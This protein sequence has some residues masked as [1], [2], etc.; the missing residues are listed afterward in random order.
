MENVEFAKIF[1]EIAEFLEIEG[2]NPFK[3]RAYQ[4]AALNIEGLSKNLE[5]IYKQGGLKAL[6]DIP[7]IGERI[8][9][10][11]EEII[12]KGR[13][14]LHQ[15]LLKKFPADFLEMIRI[16]GMGPKTVMMLYKKQGIDS[17]SMLEQ[18]AKFGKLRALPGMGEKKE[19]NILKGLELL[20]R[21]SGRYLLVDALAY[22]NQMTQYLKFRAPVDQ[23]IHCGSLRR[24]QETVGDI[25]ILVTSKRPSAVMNVFT[26][27]PGSKRVLAKGE[28]RSS[29]ILENDMQCDVRVVAPEEFGSAAHYF[30]GSKMH[31]IKIRE[32]AL[33]M[34]LKV[35]EYGVF[36]GKKRIAGKTEDEVFKAI[37]LPFIEPELREDRGE[38]EAGY[39]G[40]LPHLIGY[41]DIKG[42]LHV[43]SN[44]TDGQN[45]IEEI[46]QK[47]MQRGYQYVAITDH[48]KAVKIAGGLTEKEL[49]KQHHEIDLVNKR[50][51]GIKVLKG[52]E[53]DILPDGNLDFDDEILKDLDVVLASVHS[54]F[55]MNR[56]DMTRRVVR[57]LENPYV[58]IFTHPTGRIIN[59]REP[60]EIDLE[61]VFR[62]AVKN[63]K[64]IELNSYPSRLDLNDAHCRRAKQLGVK[65]SI[66]TDSHFKDQ[67]D[68]IFF[69]VA[70]ARRGWI[71][72]GD[73]I[74]TQ[75]LKS[76]PFVR[77]G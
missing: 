38:I 26:K 30:T 74:N 21:S 18:A 6:E 46:A 7:G 45:S 20:K 62:A 76:L 65:I 57:A 3:I 1:F 27:F 19:A 59:E 50:L 22:A 39:D 53:V 35:S 63:N 56:D 8:A 43:H 32:T 10:K 55:K 40:T 77:G 28:S 37:G 51:K 49:K 72:K 23:I 73:V 29:I 17:L 15:R 69:G 9:A 44:W 54:N 42:D 14:E 24:M 25:D 52:C 75:P 13:L 2:E 4:R 16:P 48:S 61:A 41:S 5:D 68:F 67:L 34:G 31:N 11:I 36:K 64:A 60:Y 71:E 47:A 12:K 58:D 70:T 66:N 33:K